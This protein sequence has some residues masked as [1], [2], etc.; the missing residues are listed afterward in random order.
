MLSVYAV[1]MLSVVSEFMR[2]MVYLDW[3]Q[4]VALQTTSTLGTSLVVIMWMFVPKLN[5]K[6]CVSSPTSRSR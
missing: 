1:V 4:M 5:I 6:L 2:P 3:E